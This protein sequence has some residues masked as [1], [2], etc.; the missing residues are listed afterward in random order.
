[1]S[2]NCS[3]QGLRREICSFLPSTSC[4]YGL[5]NLSRL[6]LDPLNV[7]L[8]CAV[9]PWLS[10]LLKLLVPLFLRP[11]LWVVDVI[12]ARAEIRFRVLKDNPR[13]REAM[14]HRLVW[15]TRLRRELRLA[16]NPLPPNLGVS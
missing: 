11:L 9:S 6:S 5:L 10:N 2:E 16:G 3:Q 1:M 8:F 14:I 4:N 7:E 13:V 15:S 12:Q